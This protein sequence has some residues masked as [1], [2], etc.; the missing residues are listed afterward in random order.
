MLRRGDAQM[1]FAHVPIRTERLGPRHALR[2]LHGDFGGFAYRELLRRCELP[3]VGLDFNDSARLSPVALEILDRSI[4]Y[5][6][7]ELSI[8]RAR[9]LPRNASSRQRELLSRNEHKLKPVSLGLCAD[10]QANMPPAGAQKQ[11]DLFFSGGLTSDVRRIEYPLLELLRRRGVRVATPATRLSQ[12]EFLQWCGASHLVWSPEG[13]GWD[14]FRHYEAAAAGS[15]PVMNNPWISPFQPFG[16]RHA[17]LY[18]R[19]AVDQGRAAREFAGG[20]ADDGRG[21]VE[22]VEAALKDRERLAEMADTARRHAA[23]HHTHEKIVDHIIEESRIRAVTGTG[24][25][26]AA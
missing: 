16:H 9:L 8:D 26:R 18:Y 24:K 19:S 20:L 15:V 25:A 3:L 12:K 4:C 11:F 1:V 13:R 22:T 14:C 6:K 23:A 2:M 5:F 21:L 7:R 10:R 17:G